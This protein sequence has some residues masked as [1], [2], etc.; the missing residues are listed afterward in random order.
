MNIVYQCNCLDKYFKLTFII[1]VLLH[2]P[3][4][5]P[6]VRDLAY[7]LA[8]GTHNLLAVTYNKVPPFVRQTFNVIIKNLL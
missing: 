6:L 1:K 4:E 2:D 7:A 8:P 3:Q 5:T